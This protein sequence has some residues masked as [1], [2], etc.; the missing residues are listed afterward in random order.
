MKQLFVTGQASISLLAALLIGTT[1][2]QCSFA[3]NSAQSSA[4]SVQQTGV[5]NSIVI[6]PRNGKASPQSSIRATTAH[7]SFTPP[8]S[9]KMVTAQRQR[10]RPQRLAQTTPATGGQAVPNGANQ[11]NLAA[12]KAQR[13][14]QRV[15]AIKALL[16]AHNVSD[17]DVQSAVVAQLQEQEEGR[18]ALQEAGRKLLPVLG[19]KGMP[20]TTDVQTNSQIEAYEKSVRD[21]QAQRQ[22]S[23]QALDE[24]TGF[25]KNPHLRALL[26]AMGLI[27]DGPPILS[28]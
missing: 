14:E 26:T 6:R 7:K 28:M 12:L 2:W 27:G 9:T 22:K 3:K 8:V 10:D 17:A 24:K 21:F 5:R 25:S 23:I 1:A 13:Q 19:R 18:R 4:L 11:P 20:P 15:A 16:E